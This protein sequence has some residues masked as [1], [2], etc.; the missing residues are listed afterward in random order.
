MFRLT[1]KRIFV[2]QIAVM[3]L[4]LGCVETGTVD[5]VDVFDSDPES[6]TDSDTDADSDS[7]SDADTDTDSDTDA[8]S[9]SDSDADT[10]ADTD[11]DSDSDSDSDGDMDTDLE[12]T[13]DSPPY[14]NNSVHILVY[15][16]EF[17]DAELE[18]T[19][20]QI[21]ADLNTVA[22]YYGEQ[23]YGR[24]TVTYEIH[25][26]IFLGENPIADYDDWYSFVDLYEASIWSTGVDPDN[27][28]VST[29]ILVASPQIW[30][31]NSSGGPPLMTIF[32]YGAG[33]VAHELGHTVGLYHSK[34][35]EAGDYIVGTGD[36]ETEA[37]DYGN[38][39]CMMGMGA[40]SLEEFNLVYKNYFNWLKPI[41]IQH[42]ET[43][44]TY[45]LYTFD[46]GVIGGTPIAVTIQSGNGE[47]KYW[48]EYRIRGP[49]D[50][51]E[52]VLLNLEGYFHGMP[53]GNPAFWTT[54][55]YLL[56]MTPGSLSEDIWWAEDQTDSELLVGETY[57]DHWGG[58]TITPTGTS[59]QA[60]DETAWI[61]LSIQML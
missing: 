56:D 43:S 59:D 44:G 18:W 48:V 26:E 39:Y 54:T 9:D 15:R 42:V 22:E 20:A 16:F 35:L 4:L 21:T 37:L 60:F 33:T 28:G 5:E 8:D 13:D 27:P 25:P 2:S 50:T 58:F 46:Q 57:T 52:G 61:D 19:E 41:E 49:Y 32:H 55:P 12:D 34:A 6:D 53:T 14:T 45:R 17:P 36:Y 29:R 30:Q 47:Y 1:G 31:Y 24:F 23:S 40:H 10:D 11:S 7:D 3:L 51:T 38:V